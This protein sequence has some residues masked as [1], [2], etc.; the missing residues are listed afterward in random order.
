MMQVLGKSIFIWQIS[1]ILGGDVERIASELKRAGFQSAILHAENLFIWRTGNRPALVKAL[2]AVGIVVVGCAAVYGADPVSE[3]RQ[4][5]A[6]CKE[7]GLVAFIFDAE[8]TFDASA[9]S[10]TGA[11]KLIKAFRTDAPGVLV[12]WCWW[13]LYES[14]DGFV[15]YHPK[16]VLWA[17]M[18]EG[19]GDADFGMPMAYWSWGDS[20][21]SAIAYLKE[22]WRQWRLITNKPLIPAGRAY[23]GDGGK[24]LPEAIAAFGDVARLLGA[25]GVCWWSMQ[26]ALDSVHLPGVWEALAALPSF[27]DVIEPEPKPEPTGL[28]MLAT[29]FVNIRE[30]PTTSS[31]DLG[32]VQP[33]EKVGP[34]V[35]VAGGKSGAWVHLADGRYVCA[36]DTYG[37]VYLVEMANAS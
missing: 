30:A 24:A 18:A 17:A 20:A 23:I 25:E 28:F 34:I 32:D 2:K 6:L 10:D 36:A 37:N 4:A 27:G 26:H 8:S 22:S 35:G 19:Y 31:R 15:T 16:K 9:N 21:Q 11:V 5:A 29:R 33:G 13:P 12:G 3:G 1:A 7:F 14:G